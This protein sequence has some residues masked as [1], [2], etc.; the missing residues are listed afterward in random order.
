MRRVY[1][2]LFSF[3]IFN[4]IFLPVNSHAEDATD[5]LPDPWQRG[6]TPREM[7]PRGQLHMDKRHIREKLR[8]LR[9]Q[10]TR[11]P[12]DI[13]ATPTQDMGKPGRARPGDIRITY[14][15][16]TIKKGY[17]APTFLDQLR[18]ASDGWGPIREVAKSDMAAHL[19]TE[20]EPVVEWWEMNLRSRTQRG[21]WF[22]ARFGSK[23][24]A[25][26]KMMQQQ[27]GGAA[28]M[29][30]PGGVESIGGGGGMNI[31][32]GQN[33]PSGGGAPINTGR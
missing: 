27:Q 14:D 3:L 11:R 32:P 4:L 30:P 5:P 7:K 13:Q 31:V 26:S 23:Q 1:L 15:I 22:R 21:G 19:I 28:G 16:E 8:D 9:L 24:P 18:F 10:E 25:A 2:L 33:M 17:S 6:L 20:T 29:G 12:R